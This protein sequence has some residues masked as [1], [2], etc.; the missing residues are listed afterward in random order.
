[1]GASGNDFIHFKMEEQYYLSLNEDVRSNID[2]HRIEVVNEDYSH[3]EL[4]C[5]LKSESTKKYKQLK[6]REYDLRH[7]K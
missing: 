1:M 7:K 6:D 3:D 2:I 4:W 5:K